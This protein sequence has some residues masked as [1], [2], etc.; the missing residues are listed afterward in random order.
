MSHARSKVLAT[1]LLAAALGPAPAVAGPLRVVGDVVVGE[2][3]LD[4]WT[5][6]AARHAYAGS[7][8]LVLANG[9]DGERVQVD[10][11]RRAAQPLAPVYSEALEL[12]VMDGTDGDEQVDPDLVDALHV[13]LEQIGDEGVQAKLASGLLTH[14]QRFDRF[15]KLMRRSVRKA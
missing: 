1:L 4:D 3:F 13:L 7:L 10:V 12:Y 8:R 9:A 11:V 15:P 14:D 2:A 6:V 5:V